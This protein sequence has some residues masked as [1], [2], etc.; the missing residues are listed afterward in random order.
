MA[1]LLI[2]EPPGRIERLRMRGRD[3]V[4]PEFST[5]IERVNAHVDP[6][7]QLAQQRD[8]QRRH[9]GQREHADRFRPLG[10]FDR[11]GI[12]IARLHEKAMRRRRAAVAQ[13][14]E[15]RAPAPP[16]SARRR[17]PRR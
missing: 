14:G 15:Q 1:D 7:R 4:E 8:V 13:L 2:V 16:A 10:A 12:E 11:L 6:A 3:D 17:A 9:R 5:R